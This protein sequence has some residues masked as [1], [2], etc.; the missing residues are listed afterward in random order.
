MD[1]IK[2]IF[3]M[4]GE[5][6]NSPILRWITTMS[7]IVNWK[8]FYVVIFTRL[9]HEAKFEYFDDHKLSL[10]GWD[11]APF[12]LAGPIILG[13]I[14]T[15]AMPW[16]NHLFAKWNARPINTKRMLEDNEAHKRAMNKLKNEAD[17]QS[18]KDQ[19]VKDKVV[20]IQETAEVIKNIPDEDLK[21]Q[22]K[23]QLQTNK[24]KSEIK[25]EE[26]FRQITKLERLVIDDPASNVENDYNRDLHEKI[27][28]LKRDLAGL[29]EKTFEQD[30][31]AVEEENFP[32]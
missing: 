22:A 23:E 3:T 1:G 25:D 29:P 5:R 4:V 12:W 19:I 28:R 16:I 18:E 2:D 24:S 32:F 27:V 17:M 21:K 14:F 31:V 11:W 9:D 13:I 20:S 8:A 26:L 7:V 30:V 6:V 15:L 10:T